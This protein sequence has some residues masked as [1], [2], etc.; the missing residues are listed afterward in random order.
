MGTLAVVA[1]VGRIVMM[2]ALLMVVPLAF[3]CGRRGRC[4]S[5]A[6]DAAP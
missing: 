3:A 6:F 1:L 2:F 4:R 5:M